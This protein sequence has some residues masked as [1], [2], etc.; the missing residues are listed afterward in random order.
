MVKRKTRWHKKR[1]RRTVRT[2]R[3]GYALEV[4]RNVSIDVGYGHYVADALPR[5][6][7]APS[8]RARRVLWRPQTQTA[9]P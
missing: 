4:E 8:T 9:I 3:N 2:W 1:K 5:E 6:D 7:L